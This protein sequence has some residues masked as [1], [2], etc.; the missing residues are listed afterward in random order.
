MIIQRLSRQN[1]NSKCRARTLVWLL[2]ALIPMCAVGYWYAAGSAAEP[3]PA[4]VRPAELEQAHRDFR[5]LYRREPRHT[6]LLL[7]LAEN[8]LRSNRLPLAL[9]CVAQIRTQDP[10]VGVAARRLEAQ[11]CLRA[12]RAVRLE[13]AARELLEAAHSGS[14]VRPADLQLVE[15]MLV[16]IYSLEYR[17]EERQQLLKDIRSRRRLDSLLAKQLHFPSLLASKTSQQNQRLLEFLEE[18]PDH[19]HLAAAHARYLL[20]AG[21]PDDAE[22]L[23]DRILAAHPA[24]PG[25][26]AVALECRFE[27]QALDEFTVLLGAAPTFDPS[28]PWLLTHMRAEGAAQTGDRELAQRYFKHLTVVD[29][30][31]PLYLQGLAGVL[32][33][34]TGEGL[35]ERSRLLQRALLLAELRLTLAESDRDPGALLAVAEASRKLDFSEAVL[36]FER[37]ASDRAAGRSGQPRREP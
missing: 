31:N 36:D 33:T 37:L 17:F 20:S 3:L 4:D 12:N 24:D 1:S 32:A 26:L 13:A 18:D 23:I 29:P 30:T 10:E 8:A 28:E 19:P 7:Q 25:V 35:A 22:N 2:A 5:F 14:V 6:E 9:A 11:V 21:K 16:Y 27:R 15:E 34:E